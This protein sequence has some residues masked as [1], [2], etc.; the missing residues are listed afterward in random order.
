M[1]FFGFVGHICFVMIQFC[2]RI[3]FMSIKFRTSIFKHG[4]H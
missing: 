3:C 2:V 1:G 4:R